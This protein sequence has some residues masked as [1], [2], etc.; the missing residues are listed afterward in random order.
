MKKINN[1]LV[2]SICGLLCFSTINAQQSL[3]DKL[4][5]VNSINTITTSVPFLQISP[6]SRAGGM[7][8]VGVAS[9]P[10]ANSMHWNPAKFGM[11]DDEIDFGASVSYVPWL[12]ALV[13]DVNMA[14]LSG[15]Y[16]VSKTQVL[17][18]SL[19]YFSLG[20]MTFTDNQGNQTYQFEPIEVAF[21]VAFAQKLGDYFSGAMAL[22]YIFSNLTGGVNVNGQSSQ[23]G[24]AIA[25]DI[26]GFY[27]REITL[28]DYDADFNFGLN[29]SNLGNKISYS[30]SQERNFIPINMRFG[31]GLNLKI[32][33]YNEFGVYADINK[34]LVPTPPIYQ[35]DEQG[36][37]VYDAVTG[38]PEIESGK[39]PNVP[40]PVGIINSFSDA[41]NGFQEEMREY[42]WSA[43]IEYWYAGQFALRSGYFHEHATKGNRKYFTLG[44][45][46]K[47]KVMTLDF[48]YLVPTS[49]NNPLQNTLRFSIV[50]DFQA[51]NTDE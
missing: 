38:K 48:S 22:R 50:F 5:A 16:R 46:L 44:A 21:D 41:P 30:E 17:A 8:D 42:L 43:G 26:S 28:G 6:D 23:P 49:Q 1:I 32:D 24:K 20:S 12:R 47:Y 27:S 9:S 14:Y 19:R 3:D 40:V 29:I 36:N 15:F 34:L 37:I 11:M 2:V 39:D 13:P 25:A 7:G 35:T 45:G 18:S 33:E 31:P 4:D 51:L 10:D